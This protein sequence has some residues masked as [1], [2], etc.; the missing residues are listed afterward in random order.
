MTKPIP[1]PLR[2]CCLECGK[3]PIMC[4]GKRIAAAQPNIKPTCFRAE[5]DYWR[6]SW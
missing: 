6:E 3:Y 4:L 1:N 2:P 5:D